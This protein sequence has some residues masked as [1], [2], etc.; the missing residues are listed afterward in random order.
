MLQIPVRFRL[1]LFAACALLIL[2]LSLIPVPPR[3]ISDILSWDKAQHALAYA[4]FTALGGW[5]LAPLRGAAWGMR[6]AL[7]IGIGY[8]ALIEGAQAL[9]GY[10]VAQLADAAANALGA[11]TA[12]LIW[13]MLFQRRKAGSCK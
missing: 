13:R 6:R 8:G 5:S 11:G 10:R 1:L 7:L 3:I 2:V 12:Y 9:C 4:F